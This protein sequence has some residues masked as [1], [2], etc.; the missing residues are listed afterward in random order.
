MGL[1][2]KKKMADQFPRK[3]SFDLRSRE[4]IEGVNSQAANLEAIQGGRRSE[5]GA[6]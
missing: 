3:A 5:D 4:R 6:W 2:E 1:R